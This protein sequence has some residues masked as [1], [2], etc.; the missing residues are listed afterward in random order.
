MATI[1]KISGPVVEAEGIQ[2]AKMFDVVRVGEEGLIGEIIRL[3][4]DIS[5]IQVYEDTA[6]LRPGEKVVNTGTPLSAELGPG[7]A[8][9]IFDG[10]QRPLPIIK[11]RSGDFIARVVVAAALDKKKKWKFVPS[12][13]IGAKVEEGDILGTVQETAI[14]E[15]RILVPVG[16]FGTISEI[17][18][19]EFT[20]EEPA[21]TLKLKSGESKSFP[22]LQRWEV[23][24][25][26]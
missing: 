9:S 18:E 17:K 1:L 7:L 26:R 6:G 21:Y 11:E 23:R 8:T 24:K 20:V 19:G 4:G 13:K 2:G 12:M 3:N 22:M 15:H 16:Y 5:S 10:I 25:P 14:S